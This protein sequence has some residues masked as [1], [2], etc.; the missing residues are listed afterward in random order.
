MLA[1][2][3]QSVNGIYEGLDTGVEAPQRGVNRA[4]SVVSVSCVYDASRQ[5]GNERLERVTKCLTAMAGCKCR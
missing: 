5:A 2:N 4:G 3:W 1:P